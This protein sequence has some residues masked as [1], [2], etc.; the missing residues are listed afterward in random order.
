MKR[1][2]T[3]IL[4]IYAVSNIAAAQVPT[5][6]RTELEMRA[7]NREMR[8][9]GLNGKKAFFERLL[10]DTF[11]ETDAGGNIQTKS[12]FLSDVEPQPASIKAGVD[13][14]DVRVQSYGDTAVVNFRG[15][16]WLETGG[17][18][19]NR[20]VRITNVFVRRNGRWQLIAEQRSLLPPE[21]I[22]ANVDPKILDAF[23]GQY[24]FAPNVIFTVTREGNKL[25][26]QTTG[27]QTRVEILPEN[28]TTFF[29]KGQNTQIVFVKGEKGQV[30]EMVVHYAN[31]QE[32]RMKRI[33]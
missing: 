1:A 29:I 8:D 23:T 3:I 13:F 32:M 5:T 20:F 28:E 6:N 12:E 4:L 18:K 14:D 22:V 31:G 9:A 16:Y 10:A 27:Q 17:Q 2:F 25:I 30:T 11:I 33:R 26:G 24:E 7:I 21:R 19:N 15:N